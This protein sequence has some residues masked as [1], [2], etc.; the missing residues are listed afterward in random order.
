MSAPVKKVVCQESSSEDEDLEKFKEA[1]WSF[2]TSGKNG[3][4]TAGGDSHE[5]Q[6]R[7]VNVSQHEH[8]GNELQTTPEFRAHVAKKLG[9]ILDGCISEVTAET[10]PLMEGST[11][12]EGFRLFTTSIPGQITE[13]P[14]VRRRP[15]P[16]SSDSDSE[17][18]MR[19]REAAVSITDLLTP[20]S[21]SAE[22]ASPLP[23]SPSSPSTIQTP[24]TK[25]KRRKK[26]KVKK[27]SGEMEPAEGENSP[28]PKKKKKRKPSQE[29][30]E[31]VERNLDLEIS[32]PHSKTSVEMKSLEKESLQ[33]K[34]K[35]KKKQEH[36]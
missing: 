3:T 32:A 14:P 15:I 18:E 24:D 9:T 36:R 33:Q 21:L 25:K 35:R 2:N 16:S 5:R 27:K 28:V 30:C 29:D 10:C 7:R 22:F 1:A 31:E 34:V 17:M 8:D 13:Q 19:L 4:H 6:S 11:S 12:D 20:S 23:A 26:N